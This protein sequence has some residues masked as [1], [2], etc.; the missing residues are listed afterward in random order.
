MSNH[1]HYT[2][3]P[4]AWGKFFRVVVPLPHLYTFYMFYA[5]KSTL[6]DPAVPKLQPLVQKAK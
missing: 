4:F 2:T 5:A 6:L 1:S 3:K